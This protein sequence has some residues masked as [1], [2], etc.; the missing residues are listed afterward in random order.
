MERYGLA[1]ELYS[2][3]STNNVA[4]YARVVCLMEEMKRLNISNHIIREDYQ[5]VVRQLNG[6]YKVKSNYNIKIILLIDN[7]FSFYSLCLI[8]ILETLAAYSRENVQSLHDIK[9]IL[10]NIS[11][12]L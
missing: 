5:L 6:E 2:L 1:A 11:H 12:Y 4:E 9:S 3:A 8:N 10:F 7:K